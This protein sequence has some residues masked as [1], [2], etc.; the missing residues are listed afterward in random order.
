MSALGFIRMLY[1]YN[2]WA[3]RLIWQTG[4]ST[5]TDAQF[6]QPFDYSVGGIH[7]QVVH[8]MSAEWLWFSRLT[9]TSPRAMLNPEDY[10]DRAAV[11]IKWDEI[12]VMV[13]N[14]IN[15]LT[16]NQLA[17]DV[18][19]ATTSGKVHRQSI[20]EL[21]LHLANHGT[22][23]RAQLLMMLHQL[24]APTVEQD[25]IVYLRAQKA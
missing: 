9:G 8:V 12:E 16:E 14:T 22:D 6:T 11:R 10:P 2:Y 19:Y 25:L 20:G 5:L 1:D 24:G 13:R 4:I 17:E 23:H 15:T 21:L 3:H 7:H 18:V